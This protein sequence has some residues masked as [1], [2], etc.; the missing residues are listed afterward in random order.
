MPGNS[1]QLAQDIADSYGRG[2]LHAH[3]EVK[4]AVEREELL[5]DCRARRVGFEHRIRR[6]ERGLGVLDI[7]EGSGR[8]EGEDRGPET[9]GVRF[10]NQDRLIQDIRIDLI[11]DRAALRNASRARASAASWP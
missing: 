5:V 9:G 11:Q 6:A 1:A 3:R 2:V 7:A 4:L 8:E 10:G